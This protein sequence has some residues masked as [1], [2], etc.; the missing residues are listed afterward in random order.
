[1]TKKSL[2]EILADRMNESPEGVAAIKEAHV[3]V[4]RAV[5]GLDQ[6]LVGL[7]DDPGELGQSIVRA[8]VLHGTMGNVLTAA[9]TQHDKARTETK[10]R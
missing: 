1:V 7:Q 2:T 10:D 5:R 6:S 8:L 3:L 4:A 9:L